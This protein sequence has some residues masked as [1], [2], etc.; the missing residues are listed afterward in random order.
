MVKGDVTKLPQWAQ[1]L[2]RDL[3]EQLEYQKELVNEYRGD[4]YYWEEH[5]EREYE[6]QA[7]ASL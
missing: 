7:G 6:D 2:I 4:A 1:A 5:L 3:K